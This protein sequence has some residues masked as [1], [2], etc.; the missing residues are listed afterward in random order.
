MNPPSNAAYDPLGRFRPPRSRQPLLW[1]AIAFSSG[2]LLGTYFW[3][4][5]SWWFAGA[6]GVSACAALFLRRRVR[7]ATGVSLL[8]LAAVGAFLV[9]VHRVP[10]DTGVLAFAN[11]D[12]TP[13]ITAHVIAEEPPRNEGS[14]AEQPLDVEV[15]QVSTEAGPAEVHSRVRLHIYARS[16]GL[17][18]NAAPVAW[19]HYGERLR[20]PARLAAPRDYRNPGAFDY[21]GY[22]AARG[23]VALGSTKREEVERLP[24][25]AGSR[26]ELWRTRL[27]ENVQRKIYALWPAAD[28]PLMD[29]MLL[30]DISLLRHE[31]LADFQKSGTYHVLVI[32]GLKVGILGLALLWLLRRLGASD[33]AASVATI[34]FLLAYAT[35]TGVGTPVWRA[36]LMLALYLGARLLYRGGSILNAIGAAALALLAIDPAALFDAGFQLSF[37]CV[38]IIAGIT[39]PLLERTTVPLRQALRRIDSTGYDL[40]LPPKL[41]QL[42]LDVR[43]VAQRLELFLGRRAPL[44]LLGLAGRGLVA[45][46]EFL[47]LS[48]ALQAGLALPMAWYF[49]RATLVALPAN[50]VAVPL[51]ELVMTAGITAIGMSYVSPALATFPA[52]LASAAMSAITSGVHWWGSWR[53]ADARVATPEWFVVLAVAGTLISAMVLVRRGGMLACAGLAAVAAAFLWI[54]F[55]PP[56]PRVRSGSLEVTA[57]DVGQGDSILVVTPQ[58]QTVLIDAGGMPGWVH[59]SFDVGEE[60]VSPYLWA[61]GISRLDAVAIT[62]PHADHIGGMPSI[63][64]NFRPRKLWLGDEEPNAE[65]QRLLR[66]AA[67]LGIGIADYHEGESFELGGADFRIL[68]PEETQADPAHDEHHRNDES[69]VMKVGYGATSALLEGDAEKSEEREITGEA[70]QADV[71]KVAHHGS[72]TSTIPELLQAV[73][74][75]FAVISVGARNVYGHPKPQ[76]LSRLGEAH[77]ATYRTDLD[78][79]VSFYL[80]GRRV[81]PRLGGHP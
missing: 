47:L 67:S 18:A 53:I 62:H 5:A 21:Q 68:A 55:V 72:A 10:A 9:E 35:L 8:A 76:V 15:E 4:P 65:L 54:A 24:G 57:I 77:V 26:A 42:R 64:V 50:I 6:A 38:L 48:A 66:Q 29:A 44:R 3:R 7:G 1:A 70:P 69:L 20:F 78:G 79:A 37:L 71:L 41:V 74:P 16:S 11:G 23:M 63:L 39:R 33:L 12:D 43:M 19:F 25:F 51:T 36:T 52:L 45:V 46:A 40:A 17:A 27:R 31:V 2:I 80:D 13:A 61:R 22:L 81:T 32:S 58:G 75:Q 14:E 59:S 60:V 34:A 49:H 56:R 30:G 28:A 73:H